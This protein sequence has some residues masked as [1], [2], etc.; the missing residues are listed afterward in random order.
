MF[1]NKSITLLG[2]SGSYMRNMRE[3]FSFVFSFTILM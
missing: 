2:N 3:Q 1:L